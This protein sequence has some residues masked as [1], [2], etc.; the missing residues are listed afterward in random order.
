MSS[1][2]ESSLPT[3]TEHYGHDHTRLDDLLEQVE[4]L[5]ET[6]VAAARP[7]FAE[8]KAGLERHIG[9]EE[10]IL[11]PIFESRTG[12]RDGGPTA[13]MRWEHTMIKDFLLKIHDCLARQQKTLKENVRG[14]HGLLQMHNHKEENI[15]Y[16]ALDSMI[17]SAERV[18]LFADMENYPDG[19][20]HP[21]RA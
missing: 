11:F 9:W 15:L 16:P 7:I 13:V 14:L 5:N 1:H 6:N 3:V 8:F 12:M 19:H 2:A 20:S 17:G 4:I 10:E 21:V 18:R